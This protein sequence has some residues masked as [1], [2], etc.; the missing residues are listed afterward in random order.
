MWPT[1]ETEHIIKDL[2]HT[3]TFCTVACDTCIMSPFFLILS[4]GIPAEF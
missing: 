2:A 3:F 4:C 1:L